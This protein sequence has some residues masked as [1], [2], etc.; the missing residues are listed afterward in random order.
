MGVRAFLA[1]IGAGLLWLAS[2]AA[3]PAEEA[4][5]FKLA[6]TQLEPVKWSELDGWAADDHL[7]AFATF[8]ASCRP[9]LNAKRAR[10]PRPVYLALSEV[11]RR[12]FSVRP[13]KT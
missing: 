11:C 4:D 6:D 13:S 7:A 10:D 8:Q 12:A 1:S 3:A 5:P 2:S 9:L